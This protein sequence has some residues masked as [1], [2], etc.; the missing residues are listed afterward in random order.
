MPIR[1]RLPGGEL[2]VSETTLCEELPYGIDPSRPAIERKPLKDLDTPGRL[3]YYDQSGVPH[4]WPISG[5]EVGEEIDIGEWLL[6]R[7]QERDEQGRALWWAAEVLGLQEW[8]S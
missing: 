3:E 8:R 4:L 5:Y 2:T 7:T 1:V 6:I